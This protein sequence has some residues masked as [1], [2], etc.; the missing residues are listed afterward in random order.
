MA[1]TFIIEQNLETT[2]WLA[3][4]GRVVDLILL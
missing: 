4:I 1:S 3:I 2:V